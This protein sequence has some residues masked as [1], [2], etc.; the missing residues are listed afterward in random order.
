VRLRAHAKA[1]LAAPGSGT[2]GR[3]ACLG[4]GRPQLLKSCCTLSTAQ[5]ASPVPMARPISLAPRRDSVS[6]LVPS[7]SG[8]PAS[9]SSKPKRVP[10][11]CS[12]SRGTPGGRRS[13]LACS[14]AAACRECARRSGRYCNCDS[15]GGRFSRSVDT[16]SCPRLARSSARPGPTS[17]GLASRWRRAGQRRRRGSSLRG[18]LRYA[19][20]AS[21][22]GH[23]RAPAA[24]EI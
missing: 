21:K 3:G 19:A 20:Q 7:R 15:H 5:A 1:A 14:T 17:D 23:F 11:G 10:T 22:R 16:M 9:C 24:K 8:Q 18:G 13:S 6:F 12:R 2:P 4:V